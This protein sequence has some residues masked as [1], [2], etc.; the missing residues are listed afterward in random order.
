MDVLHSA[1]L[2]RKCFRLNHKTPI[3]GDG[4]SVIPAAACAVFAVNNRPRAHTATSTHSEPP[5]FWGNHRKSVQTSLIPMQPVTRQDLV[6]VVPL[7]P[8]TS[9]GRD[10]LKTPP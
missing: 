7:A 1:A 8:S 5:G 4:V 3:G 9:S 6:Q 10:G 2:N